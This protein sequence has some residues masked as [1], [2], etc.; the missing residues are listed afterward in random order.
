MEKATL[1]VKRVV[2]NRDLKDF[3]MLPWKIYEK[4][5]NW[6][7]P[8]ISDF[9]NT[10]NKYK[11][12][13]FCHAE[14]E[15]YLA[16][17]GNEVV[18]RIAAIIDY[19]YCRYHNKNI[20]FFGFFDVA[21]DYPAAEAL[22]T[23]VVKYLK[24]KIITEMYGPTNPSL[25]DEAGF[26]VQGFNSPPMIKMSYNPE[27]YLEFVEQFGMK[28]VKD[29]Y[30]Y[31]IE[32]QRDP[33]EKLAR[34]VASLK[35]RKN[36]KVR[37]INLRNLKADLVIIKDI[38]NNA[39][40]HNWDFSPMTEQEIDSLAKQ[41][42]PLIVPE[43]VPIVE[44]DGEP[45]GMSIGLPDYNQVLKHLNGRLFPFGIF[46]FLKYKNKIDALRL[47]A[48]GVKEKYRNTGVDALLYYETFL[49]AKRLGYKLSEVSW[50]LEDNLSIINPIL[51]W[52]AKLYKV[53][54][55]YKIP[56]S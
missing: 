34:V 24:S 23:H 29:L 54:R 49:G 46:K 22:L 18:G 28:K 3:V 17:R 2:S 20:G 48:L 52:G 50:I 51:L 4:D 31:A 32:V 21:K 10:L 19:N 42:K 7:P 45:A 36:I 44:V 35:K 47:W 6:V 39:W 15:L 27:Y 43:I 30:A 13:F 5:P 41:L 1:T 11:N 16:F 40:S 38:Y 37:P 53:Y 9:R 26:L 25:N 55:V 14:R 12:P 33:P 8:I 56:I